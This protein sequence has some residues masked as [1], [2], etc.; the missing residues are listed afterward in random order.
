MDLN[1]IM[2]KYTAISSQYCLARARTDFRLRKRRCLPSII[3]MDIINW[4]E[5]ETFCTDSLRIGRLQSPVARHPH[6]SSY[7]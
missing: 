7:K 1:E 4:F 6:Q 5:R 3:K 2:C